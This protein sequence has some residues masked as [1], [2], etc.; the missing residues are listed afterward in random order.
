MR[1]RIVHSTIKKFTPSHNPN[2]LPL[3]S[4]ILS[5]QRPRTDVVL[6][7]QFSPLEKKRMLPT[8][9][10]LSVLKTFLKMLTGET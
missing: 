4:L 8:H 2:S 10:K 6:K 3:T 1:R 7:E 5:Y 9:G